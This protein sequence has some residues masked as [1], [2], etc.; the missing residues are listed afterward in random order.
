M[1]SWWYDLIAEYLVGISIFGVILCD[2][3]SP[4]EYAYV[5][6][7]FE[8]VLV[9]VLL[10]GVGIELKQCWGRWY[11]TD[12]MKR[13]GAFM[14]FAQVSWIYIFL[15][16]LLVVVFSAT[17]WGVCEYLC[18]LMC[19]YV[20]RMMRHPFWSMLI[21]ALCVMLIVKVLALW[22]RKNLRIKS[23]GQVRHLSHLQ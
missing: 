14:R 2:D 10:I 23:C 11:V 20:T 1:R 6:L 3:L 22:R 17:V 12:V 13:A 16:V 9:F 5:G 19:N 4:R 7:F 8:L 21:T 18:G 15:L